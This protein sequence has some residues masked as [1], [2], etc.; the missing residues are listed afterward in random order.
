MR[1]C[2]AVAFF[3]KVGYHASNVL[4]EVEFTA[5]DIG[6]ANVVVVVGCVLDVVEGSEG[7]YHQTA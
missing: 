5:V 4:K 2:D 7:G 1:I 3:A 6:I